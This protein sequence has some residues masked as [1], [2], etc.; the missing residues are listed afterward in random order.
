MLPS[1]TCVVDG[2]AFFTGND[3]GVGDCSDWREG[4]RLVGGF[5][6]GGFGGGSTHEGCEGG[7]EGFGSCWHFCCFLGRKDGV[8]LIG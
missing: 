8:L 2:E 7:E 5:F 3:E 4:W 1:C 6:V